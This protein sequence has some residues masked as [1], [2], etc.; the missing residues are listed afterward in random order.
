VVVLSTFAVT[1]IAET[2]PNNGENDAQELEGGDSEY[3]SL[4]G[5]DTEDWYYVEL[6]P[7]ARL[8]VTLELTSDSGEVWLYEIFEGDEEGGVYINI[9]VHSDYREGEDTYTNDELETIKLFLRVA[10]EGNYTI[11]VETSGGSVCCMGLVLFSGSSLFLVFLGVFL[12]VKRK[13]SM[14]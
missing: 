3:G 2:E 11:G 12:I 10:G 13:R 1:V 5:S 4:G 7:A 8:T 6:D 9:N 14:I